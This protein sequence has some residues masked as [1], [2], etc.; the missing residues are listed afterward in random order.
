VDVVLTNPDGQT[1]TL[2]ASFTYLP[3]TG[4][5]ML[6]PCR[7]L[8][9]RTPDGVLGGPALSPRAWR[10]FQITGTCGIPSG[11]VAVIVN[12]AVTSPTAPGTIQIEGIDFLSFSAGQTRA[13]N[14]FVLLNQFGEIYFLNTS[15]GS[16]HVLLDVT[17]Y[18]R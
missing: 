11:A 9:T 16:A 17:G 7:V 15:A 6:P 14:G 13:N 12:A 10:G 8:D 4:A 18:F 5:Y 1:A 2:P 3:W